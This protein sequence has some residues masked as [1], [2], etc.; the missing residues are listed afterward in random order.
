MLLNSIFFFFQ[1]ESN[2]RVFNTSLEDHLST[3]GRKISY[4]I[5]LCV[6]C[7]L[8]KGLYEEGLLRVGCGEWGGEIIISNVLSTFGQI[9]STGK[10]K[11]MR[12]KSAIDASFVQPPIPHEY[13]DVHVI[14]S[15]LKAYLRSL[16]EP[17]L[18]Y[19][20]YDKFMEVSQ[21]VNDQHR[22]AAILN[23]IHQLPSGN[24]D[25]LKYLMKF[26]TKLS[27]KHQQ[28]KMSTQNIAIVMSPNLLWPQNENDQNYA[29][30]VSPTSNRV[31][32]Q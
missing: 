31:I 21:I 14:A 16:P 19:G 12:M 32:E 9:S 13:Q 30:Q 15:V 8:E 22:K 24:Y 4:V 3:T 26:L 5:E 29:Q 7:L 11:L 18:T 17:L 27:E 28:N 6:C 25:N 2:K 23:I 10:S 1:G 20:F